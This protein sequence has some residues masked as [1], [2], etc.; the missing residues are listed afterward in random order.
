MGDNLGLS[1]LTEN[2]VLS[3][4]AEFDKLRRDE[5]LK[6]YG[7]SRSRGYFINYQSLLYDSK[8]IAGAAHGYVGGGLKALSVF[9]WFGTI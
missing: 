4:I 5:F 6:K 2:A 1:D 8:A 7:F 9:K 3:A